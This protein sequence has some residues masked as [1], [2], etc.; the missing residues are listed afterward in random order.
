MGLAHLANCAL[1]YPVLAFGVGAAIRRRPH[2]ARGISR[3]S[4]VAMML[5]AVSLLLEQIT[6]FQAA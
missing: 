3:L 1:L 5:V 2:W 4:G 6:V